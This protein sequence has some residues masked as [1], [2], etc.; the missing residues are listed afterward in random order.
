MPHESP[1]LFEDKDRLAPYLQPS[2]GLK[3]HH[4]AWAKAVLLLMA[5]EEDKEGRERARRKTN[6]LMQRSPDYQN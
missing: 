3:S 1:G 6:S 5:M 2:L 4:R